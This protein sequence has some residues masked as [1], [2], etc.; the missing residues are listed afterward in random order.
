VKAAT[1]HQLRVGRDGGGWLAEVY[2][3]V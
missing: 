1:Y 3:D 2:L